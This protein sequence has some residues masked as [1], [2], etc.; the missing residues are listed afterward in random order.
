MSRMVVILVVTLIVT[1]GSM[2]S[3]RAEERQVVINEVAWGGTKA[4]PFDE[5]IELRNNTQHLI[6]LTG[7]RLTSDDGTP[8]IKLTGIIPAGG[9]YLLE[10]TDDHTVSDIQADQ[11]YTGALSN[12]G[13]CLELLDR[14]GNIVDTANGHGGSW[15]AGA[16]KPL[17]ISMLIKNMFKSSSRDQLLM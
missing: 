9:F 5:W 10:R 15:P 16:G 14:E 4:S 8:V 13:E 3:I 11:V 12:S 2:I 7:W 6:D 17:Y 1:L